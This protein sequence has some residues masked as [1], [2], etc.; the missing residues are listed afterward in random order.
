MRTIL[1]PPIRFHAFAF[2]LRP[3][4]SGPVDPHYMNGHPHLYL[5]V[6]AAVR[7]LAC[8]S[9]LFFTRCHSDALEMAV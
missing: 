7:L 5:D 6:Q 8:L 1:H 9:V 2:T 4:L 3:P